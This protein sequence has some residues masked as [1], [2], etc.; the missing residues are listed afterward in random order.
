MLQLCTNHLVLVLC[1]P[2]W[3]V[4]ACQF[5]LIPSWSSSTPLYP[6][7]VL[8]AKELAWLLALL[9]FF[10]WDSPLE[11][12]KEL[13]ACHIVF[14]N[15]HLCSFLEHCSNYIHILHNISSCTIST[16]LSSP[17]FSHLDNVDWWV[18]IVLGCNLSFPFV[19]PPFLSFTIPFFPLTPSFTLMMA[20]NEEVINHNI[21]QHQFKKLFV[22]AWN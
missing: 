6:S 22:R 15:T 18:N 7:K 11:S 12:F 21:F 16:F 13:G 3:V 14:T 5:F 9:L 17:S 20:S 10:V 19:F 4:E 2:V 8:Q 1:K